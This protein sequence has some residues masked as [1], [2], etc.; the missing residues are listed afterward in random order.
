MRPLVYYDITIPKDDANSV[1][2]SKDRFEDILQ[3]VYQAG[4]NDA[5]RVGINYPNLGTPYPWGWNPV[6]IT[7]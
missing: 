5:V 1:I 7:C 3:E 6:T 2:L 4:Y